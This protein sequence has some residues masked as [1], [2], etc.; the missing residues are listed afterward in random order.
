MSG[1]EYTFALVP[2]WVAPIVGAMAARHYRAIGWSRYAIALAGPAILVVLSLA[3]LLDFP[4]L[5]RPLPDFGPTGNPIIYSGMVTVICLFIMN[6][7]MSNPANR[8]TSNDPR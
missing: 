1:H 8:R 4:P 3:G 7:I 5:N 6:R 2:I